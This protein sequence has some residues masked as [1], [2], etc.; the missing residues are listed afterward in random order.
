MSK[1]KEILLRGIQKLI[2]FWLFDAPG[3]IQIRMLC[4]KFVVTDIGSNCAIE[5]N[6]IFTQPDGLIGGKLIIGERVQITPIQK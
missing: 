2:G 1:L 3:L 4:Y 6:V 5:H